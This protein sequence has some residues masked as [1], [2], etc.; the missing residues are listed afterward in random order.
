MSREQGEVQVDAGRS[1]AR[2]AVLPASLA[3]AVLVAWAWQPAAEPAA[4]A[5][6]TPAAP[7]AA[8]PTAGAPAAPATGAVGEGGTRLLR[9]PAVGERAIVF[10]YADD[11]WTVSR[12][13][14]AARR[15]TTYQGSEAD[16]HLSPD[17]RWI[18]FT[19]Q[20]AGNTDVYVIPAYG[21]EPRRLTWHPG[22][23]EAR[24]WTPDGRKVLFTSARLSPHGSDNAQV[25][26]LFTIG[27]DG[28]LPERLPIPDARRGEFSP[29]GRQLAWESERWQ[30]EWR[31]YR[32]GQAHPIRIL[33]LPD[34][35]VRAVP[36][37]RSQNQHPVW[38]GGR[39]YFLSDRDGRMNVYE[40]DPVA[41]AVRALTRHEDFDVKWLSAGGGL[42][43]Y[44]QG[45]YI[46]TLD[47]ASGVVRRLAIE[48][49][50]D[51][52]WALPHWEDVAEEVV[53]AGLSPTGARALFEARGE[54]FTVPAEKGDV[55]DVS[56]HSAADRSPAWSPDGSKIAWFS[57]R[58]GE[59]RLYIADQDGQAEPR[60]ITIEPATFFFGLAWSPD[61]KKLAFTDAGRSLYV[62]DAAGG[63]PTK[64]D[65]DRMAHP[66]RS[67]APAWSPDSRFIA[68]ARQM[69]NQYRAIWVYSIADGHAR[70]LTD[71]LSDAVEPVW[72]RGGKYLYFMASTDLA[73]N[74][75]WLDLSSI[76]RPFRRGVY[77]AVL[78][79]DLPS[80]L[81]PESDD[82]KPGGGSGAGEAGAGASSASGKTESKDAGKG[83]GKAGDKGGGKGD[84]KE[85]PPEVKI[86]WDGIGQRIL[87]LP[88]PVRNYVGIWAGTPGVVFVAEAP[89]PFPE[90]S[91]PQPT[92][93]LQ[94]WDMEKRKSAPFLAGLSA[95]DVSADGK[96]ALYHAA[97]DWGIVPTDDEPK[98][99][100]G[101]VKMELRMPI[102][103]PAEWAQIYREAWRFERDFFYVPNH[104]GADWKAVGE[105]Y[106]AWVPHV[107]H[108][109]DLSYLIN[110][111]G[112]EHGVG[113][114]FVFGG[115]MPETPGISTGL[116]GAD[117]AVDNGRY[118][119]TR[120]YTGENWNPDLQAPLSAPGVDVKVGDYL[121]A[122][123]GRELKPPKSPY[124]ALEGTAGRQTRL[125]VNARPS[126]DGARTVTVVPV[127]SERPLRNRAWVEDN[128]RAVDRLSG[129]R[130]AYIWLPDTGDDGYAYFNRYYFAQQDRKGAILD[131]RFN[132][133]GLVADYIIDIVGRRLRGYFSNPVGDR[134]PWTEPMSGIWG[135][136][137]MLINE[138]AGSGGDMLPFMFRQQAL[139][140]LVG[141]TTWGGLVGI[142]D[143]PP[144]I[145]GGG[146]SVPRGGF[147][148]LE[149]EWDVEN[150]GVAP[151]IAVEITPKDM[152]G[153]RD[154]QLD[155]AVAEA[156]RMLE[157]NP[158]QLL[159]EPAPPVRV[160]P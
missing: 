140:P 112:G 1:R 105:R 26:Q 147:F 149:G 99:G 28:G 73:L 22:A 20:Y 18:A 110:L 71:G 42:L 72:D 130:L 83:S 91:N 11:L 47:P 92:F 155:R 38:L 119:I 36:G 70:Q 154:P 66:D 27:L 96:K 107:R 129:G 62:V 131:E 45:G 33:S 111:M 52:P 75:G 89:L 124:E 139:G 98:P 79:R 41:G 116:L 146:I 50:G 44:E 24:G 95:F 153:G 85:P 87:A 53:D 118:R 35:S 108:R 145:D 46:H 122:V 67:M 84:G 94:R 82:E 102:D 125:T 148:N 69:P 59:Y 76:E 126:M 14:G 135:P 97:E 123:E 133:G 13:G 144:L 160:K 150:E 10:A 138:F 21:G 109:A 16:P 121:L 17:G 137:V 23:D 19:G 132:G 55:R 4:P 90:T 77:F 65:T 34:L 88:F 7:A 25:R 93:A 86:D 2:A 152:A 49:D 104:H 120:I 43:A 60:A 101:K 56:R 68:Y 151:D 6:A 80:P 63:K 39:L 115:D 158:V 48:V 134:T 106:A 31:N 12:E 117:L 9:Q 57:D 8:T 61:A 127:A 58:T 78:A 32:G 81:L 54:I 157:K 5:A 37:P 136:K 159:R 156:L 141:S 100:D 113:H 15:L 64:V 103:P 40:F 74:T 128:R 3:L 29:D 114:H 51:F 142:W 143:F 30:A